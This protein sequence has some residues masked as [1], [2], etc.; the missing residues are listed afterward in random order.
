[1]AHLE[2]AA[3][4][5]ASAALSVSCCSGLFTGIR[6]AQLCQIYASLLNITRI[7]NGIIRILGLRETQI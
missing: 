2:N 7:R 1:M 6:S 3:R 4:N 5:I